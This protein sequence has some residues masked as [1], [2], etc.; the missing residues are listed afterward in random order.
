M[1]A[2]SFQNTADTKQGV[3]KTFSIQNND[4]RGSETTQQVQS[5]EDLRL[6][7]WGLGTQS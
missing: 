3:A 4:L 1:F 5:Q 7:Q 2:S 6:V